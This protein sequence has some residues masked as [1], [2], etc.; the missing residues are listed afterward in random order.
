MDESFPTANLLQ[1]LSPCRYPTDTAEEIIHILSRQEGFS[2]TT[3][4]RQLLLAA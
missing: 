1:W 4:M 2:A 3:M